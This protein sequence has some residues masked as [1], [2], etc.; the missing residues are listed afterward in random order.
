MN[1]DAVPSFYILRISSEFSQK[2]NK[3]NRNKGIK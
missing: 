3:I 2:F 1:F